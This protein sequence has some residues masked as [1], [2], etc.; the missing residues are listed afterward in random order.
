MSRVSKGVAGMGEFAAEYG[1]SDAVD[2]DGWGWIAAR[3]NIGSSAP[4]ASTGPGGR[5]PVEPQRPP[6]GLAA[7]RAREKG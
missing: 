4:D 6:A 5:R 3:K 7:Q 1:V 2:G